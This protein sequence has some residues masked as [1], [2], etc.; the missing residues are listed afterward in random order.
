MYWILLGFYLIILVF[1]GFICLYWIFI[2]LYVR[3][4]YK[5]ACAAQ[6]RPEVP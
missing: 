2:R 1:I 5:L 6:R 3:R 4:C